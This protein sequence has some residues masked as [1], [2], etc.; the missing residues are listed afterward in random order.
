MQ[1]SWVFYLFT[2][3]VAVG[4]LLQ[5]VVMLGMAMA[6][7]KAIRRA[8]EL[9]SLVQKHAVPLMITTRE[10][11]EDVSP[12]LKD[13]AQ[14]V[15]EASKILRNQAAQANQSLDSVLKKAEVQVDR[16]DEMVT[17][18]LDSI[19]YATAAVQ[20]A[21][22]IPVRQAGALWTG[23]QVGFDVLL[24]RDRRSHSAADG[25]HFV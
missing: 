20:R 7:M 19:A 14:N 25:D 23:I 6:A 4:V 8:N 22:A 12:K 18:T 3:L 24:G 16:V 17:G 21:V 2:A 1:I 13:A 10:L 5:G 9:S 15:S 11:L